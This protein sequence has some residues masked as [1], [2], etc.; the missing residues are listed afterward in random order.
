MTTALTS[1]PGIVPGLT[2]AWVRLYCTGMSEAARELRLVEIESDLWE[3]FADRA[4]EGVSSAA[5]GVETL[6]RLLRGIPSDI[7]WRF[8]A[9][10]FHMNISFPVERLAGLLLLFLIVPF[11]AG[12]SISGYDVGREA[13]P[14]EFARFSKISTRTRELTGLSHAAIGLG[15]IAAATLLFATLRERSP[16]LITLAFGLLIAAGVTML[17]NAGLY[18]AMSGLADDYALSGEASLIASARSFALAIELLSLV[19]VVATTFAI[20]ATSAAMI[21]L[22]MVP[23]WTG[24]FPIVG[25]TCAVAYLSFSSIGGDWLWGVLI[26]SWFS[27][28][29]WLVICGAWLLLGGASKLSAMPPR[30]APA[31]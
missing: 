30:N 17:V 11:V 10:G 6:S 19:N 31:M 14:D 26:L 9:E 28:A 27:L 4:A 20:L 13:W 24:S 7:A 5:T 3:H 22:A 23:K 16:K 1:P 25:V 12:I 21:R 18:R 8:Q 29:L 2:R 15:L